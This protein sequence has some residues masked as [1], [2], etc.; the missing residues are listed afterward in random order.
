M[1]LRNGLTIAQFDSF[2]DKHINDPKA[3]FLISLIVNHGVL[4]VLH[5]P[6]ACLLIGF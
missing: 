3:S 1:A 2:L 4:H 5:V 6:F